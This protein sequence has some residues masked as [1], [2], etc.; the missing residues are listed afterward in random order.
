MTKPVNRP[1]TYKFGPTNTFSFQNNRKCRAIIGKFNVENVKNGLASFIESKDVQMNGSWE[2]C[3]RFVSSYNGCV[4]EAV[5]TRRWFSDIVL[6]NRNVGLI[7][8]KNIH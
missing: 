5:T 4:G 6:R 3:Q 2:F 1:F 7:K 8:L